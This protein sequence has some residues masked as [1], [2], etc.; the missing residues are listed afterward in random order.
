MA[1]GVKEPRN[2]R[3]HQALHGYADG[4]RQLAI[5]TTLKPKDQKTLLA[6]SDISGPGAKLDNSGYLTGYPLSDSG[7]YALAKTWPAPEMSRPGCV[8]THTILIDFNDLATLDSLSFLINAFKRPSTNS[9]APHEYSKEILVKYTNEEHLSDNAVAWSKLIL[10]ALYGKPKSRIIISRHDIKLDVV[11]LA[12]W[13]Q[14]WPRLRRG[15]RFCTFSASDRSTEVS[16][17][18]LQVLPSLDR[19]VRSRFI[20]AVDAENIRPAADAWVN[21]AIYDLTH[22]DINGLRTFFRRLGSDFAGGREIFRALCRL[23]RAT[24]AIPHKPEAINEAITLLQGELRS[25]HAKLAKSM[26][27]NTAAFMA[28]SLDDSSFDFLWSNLGLIDPTALDLAAKK[29]GQAAWNRY[30][31]RFTDLLNHESDPDNTLFEK[32]LSGLTTESLLE[33]LQ[34]APQLLDVTLTKHPELI[35]EKNFWV[36]SEEK[37]AGLMVAAKNLGLQ[38]QTA[39]ALVKADRFDL[40]KVTASIFGPGYILEALAQVE[41]VNKNSLKNWINALEKDTNLIAGFLANH[42]GIQRQTLYALTQIYLPDSI[43]NNYGGDPWLVAWERSIGRITESEKESLMAYFLSRALGFKSRSQAELIQV[44]FDT[45]HSALAGDRLPYESWRHLD[46]L[47]PWSI[48]WFSWD[49][50]QRLR[51][52]VANAFVTRD[53]IPLYFA[54]VT[55]DENLFYTISSSAAQSSRGR[56]YLSRVLSEMEHNKARFNHRI[57]TVKS[58]VE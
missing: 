56:K 40:A 46:A 30:P 45:V 6:L 13:A 19:S 22:P 37:V 53:L 20:D 16:P 42:A 49:R 52:G 33:G 34:E 9:L 8:W 10:T 29:I 44:S 36:G 57:M 5:S 43:P 1:N 15:F 39:Q 14:Q 38:A 31:Q 58:L 28:E 18:D 50:C 24:S 48:L 3:V 27:T 51:A 55:D 11:V 4:H 25:K 21:A 32:L 17:F 12:I 2:L 41:D 7:F 35:N 26:L 23:Y 54:Q 47:L